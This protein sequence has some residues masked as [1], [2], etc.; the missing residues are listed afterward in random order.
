MRLSARTPR[1]LVAALLAALLVPV[2]TAPSGA[3]PGATPGAA[4]GVAAAPL[5]PAVDAL[6][7]AVDS[8]R[9]DEATYALERVA[10]MVDLDAVRAR[11]GEVNLPDPRD[12]T[13]LLRE[14]ALRAHE[15]EG[16]ARLRARAYLARPT[17]GAA[18][19]DGY[20]YRVD[21]APPLCSAN[22]CIHYVPRTVD[23]PPTIDEAPADGVPDWVRTTLDVV[24]EVWAFEVDGYGY[25][26]PKADDA[27]KENGGDGRLDVYLVDIGR[28]GYYGFCTSDDPNL[29]PS[30]RYRYSDMSAYCV[31]DDD[32]AEFGYAD[33]TEPLQVTAAHEFFHAVQFAYDAFEDWWIMEATAT[34]IEDEVYPSI[35]DNLQYLR[36]SPLSDPHVPLDKGSSPAWYGGWIFFRFLSEYLGPPGAPDPTIVRTIWSKMD[37]APGGQDRYSTQALAS[38]LAERTIAGA[39]GEVA[40]VLRDFAIWNTVPKAFYAEGRR[41]RPAD[42]AEGRTLRGATASFASVDRIDHLANRL[43]SLKRGSGVPNGARLRI[44]IDGPKA[45]AAPAAGVVVIARSGD[46]STRTIPLDAAGDG[47]LKVA[48]GRTVSRVVVIATNGSIRFRRCWTG[49][50]RYSCFGGTPVDDGA[51]FAVSA[52][53][54]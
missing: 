10:S 17:Q 38:A 33:P 23:A 8:G 47:V 51:S 31:L 21:E 39:S 4:P 46:V 40:G 14:L 34:W 36:R 5:L 54:V 45:A 41:Y 13:M 43:V 28:D 18:D 15:L 52:A 22:A 2:G 1:A 24:D 11:F 49:L 44:T 19:P 30:R 53:V 35:D 27:S 50:T 29:K 26:A 37:G 20:G 9:I 42:I 6:A 25:R 16:A 32:Y 7:R 3:T 12:A 48:F